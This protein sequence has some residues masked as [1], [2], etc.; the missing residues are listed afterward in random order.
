M[1][2][3]TKF[4]DYKILENQSSWY[5]Q[6]VSSKKLKVSIFPK[7]KNILKIW[8]YLQNNNVWLADK[9]LSDFNE[10]TSSMNDDDDENYVLVLF[11][12]IYYFHN[13][14]SSTYYSRSLNCKVYYASQMQ[15]YLTT[16][17]SAS[18]FLSVITKFQN[19]WNN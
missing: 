4:S 13:F 10:K 16:L 3:T 9:A 6:V 1:L 2:L 11:I 5:C 18:S 12:A 14:A 19:S 17:L 15:Y 7:N 8:W